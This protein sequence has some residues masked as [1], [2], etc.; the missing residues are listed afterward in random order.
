MLQLL[1]MSLPHRRMLC[2]ED[3]TSVLL[4][5]FFPPLLAYMVNHD[6]WVSDACCRM[7]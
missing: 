5:F 6:F 1:L 4:F 2:R 7:L 3:T